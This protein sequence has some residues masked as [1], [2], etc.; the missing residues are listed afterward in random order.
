[1][2]ADKFVEFGQ[3]ATALQHHTVGTMAATDEL[4]K[5]HTRY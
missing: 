4:L 1:M 2:L 3:K 5:T